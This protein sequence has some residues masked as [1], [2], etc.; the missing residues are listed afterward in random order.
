MSVGANRSLTR[1]SDNLEL[2]L[3]AVGSHSTRALEAKV[4]ALSKSNTYY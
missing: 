3:Q 1:I 2:E 4:H